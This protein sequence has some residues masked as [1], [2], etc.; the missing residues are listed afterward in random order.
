MYLN[1]WAILSE[2]LVI[3]ETIMYLKIYEKFDK[4]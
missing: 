2:P 1:E 4:I 3:D